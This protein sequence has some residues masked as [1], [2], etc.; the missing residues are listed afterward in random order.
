MREEDVVMWLIVNGVWAGVTGK[1]QLDVKNG[2][3]WGAWS[4]SEWGKLSRWFVL[5]C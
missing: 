1:A 3:Y 4:P 5:S 2:W